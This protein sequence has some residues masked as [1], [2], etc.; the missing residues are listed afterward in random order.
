MDAFLGTGRQIEK[1]HHVTLI[2]L[3]NFGFSQ[4]LAQQQISL[5]ILGKMKVT[6]M[7]C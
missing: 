7:F 3:F 1:E 4:N 5:K 2:S 6:C